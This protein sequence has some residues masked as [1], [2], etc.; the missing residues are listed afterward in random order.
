M[1]GYGIAPSL[2]MKRFGF[3]IFIYFKLL[4]LL[5]VFACNCSSFSL[6]QSKK[7]KIKAQKHWILWLCL[8]W[9][10]PSRKYITHIGS[11][12]N[13]AAGCW[14]RG[15]I[16]IRQC[17]NNAIRTN[18]GNSSHL[19]PLITQRARSF[20]YMGN[21]RS[22]FDPLQTKLKACFQE[23][24][25]AWRQKCIFNKTFLPLSLYFIK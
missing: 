21:P 3:V 9:Q 10:H 17:C 1:F 20:I 4:I 22:L 7:N 14:H 5:L 13:Q 19:Q 11:G 15:T 24:W 6:A 8:F 18:S 12:S 2:G 23:P 25:S 16:L